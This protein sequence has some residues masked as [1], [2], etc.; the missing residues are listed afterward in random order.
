MN[1]SLPSMSDTT[2]YLDETNKSIDEI[3]IVCKNM[4]KYQI[5][6]NILI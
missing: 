5:A 6:M 3:K 1:S 4:P 2:K